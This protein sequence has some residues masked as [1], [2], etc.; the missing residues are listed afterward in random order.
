[1]ERQMNEDGNRGRR[2]FV[3]KSKKKRTRVQK[4]TGSS[5]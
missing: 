1:M 3:T 2:D 5:T 4:E